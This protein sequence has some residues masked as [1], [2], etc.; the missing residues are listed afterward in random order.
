MSAPDL[1][2]RYQEKRAIAEPL[3]PHVLEK[4]GVIPDWSQRSPASNS[5]TIT[6]YTI[7][8]N[9]GWTVEPCTE[10]G[11][12]EIERSTPAT[13]EDTVELSITQCCAL[14]AGITNTVIA[15]I[16]CKQDALLSPL[17]WTLSSDFTNGQGNTR[18]ELHL[19]E[20]MQVEGNVAV[21]ICNGKEVTRTIASPMTSDFSLMEAAGSLFLSQQNIDGFEQWE[22]LTTIRPAQSIIINDEPALTMIEQPIDLHRIIQIGQGML[23]C[24]YWLD[25]SQKLLLC[26]AYNRVLIRN[27]KARDNF[28]T[29]GEK[30]SN[31]L[32]LS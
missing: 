23:P 31:L 16:Q 21:G 22:T 13:P 20:S 29:L 8:T 17:S 4:I 32:P 1:S 7:W 5:E 27:D 24:E 15:N 14:N 19:E 11:F 28:K 25:E 3:S 9:H 30:N 2:H 10:T 18:P 26:I 6:R 12:L